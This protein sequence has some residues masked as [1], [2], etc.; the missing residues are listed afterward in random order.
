MS[1]TL[2]QLTQRFLILQNEAQE[3]LINIAHC[4]H[5]RKRENI[6]NDGETENCLH[7]I[8]IGMVRLYFVERVREITIDIISEGGAICSLN[9]YLTGNPSRFTIEAIEET[10][11][12]SFL[13]NDIESLSVQ[14]PDVKKLVEGMISSML[15]RLENK[16]IE[17]SSRK[18]AARLKRWVND[19]GG[20]FNRIPQSY[21][22]SYFKMNIATF[23]RL[24]NNLFWRGRQV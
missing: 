9:S 12:Y 18:S 3:A 14:Y 10:T 1:F 13:K 4:K 15:V 6:I 21:L 24:K 17:Y 22:A 2:L 20:L 16:D 7:F 5:Y 23:S 11:T 8:S 19:N